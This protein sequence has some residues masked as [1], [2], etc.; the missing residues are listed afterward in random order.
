MNI[1]S[2]FD[3]LFWRLKECG[4]PFRKFVEVDFSSVTAKKIRMIRKPGQPNLVEM[5]DGKRKCSL[6]Q[7]INDAGLFAVAVLYC[8]AFSALTAQILFS[9][10]YNTDTGI[11]LA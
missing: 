1:G 3:T 11:L 4:K 8:P 5:F 7:K 6:N 2:G 9:F 10:F